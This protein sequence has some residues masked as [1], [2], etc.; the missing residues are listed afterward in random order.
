M[1]LNN[2]IKTNLLW[3]IKAFKY[4]DSVFAQ[5]QAA[6]VSPEVKEL[7]GTCGKLARMSRVQTERL[8]D[9]LKNVEFVKEEDDDVILLDEQDVEEIKWLEENINGAKENWWDRLFRNDGDAGGE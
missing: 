7:L 1:D 9:A 8:N 4:F 5:L 6:K 3:N 2:D